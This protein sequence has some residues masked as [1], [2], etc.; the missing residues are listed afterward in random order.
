MQP[1]LADFG[2]ACRLADAVEMRKILGSPALLWSR[3]LSC[4]LWPRLDLR[5]WKTLASSRSVLLARSR[6]YNT[7]S[8]PPKTESA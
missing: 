3:K 6:L 2:I 5:P 1:V 4:K 8:S 7:K